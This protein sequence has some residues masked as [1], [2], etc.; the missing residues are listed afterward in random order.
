MLVVRT[1]LENA[2]NFAGLTSA[3]DFE[4]CKKR[5]RL[6]Y[7]NIG[8]VK[9]KIFAGEII[10]LPYTI[11]QKDRRVRPVKVTDDRRKKFSFKGI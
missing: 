9:A 1:Y 3:L 6:Y 11:L 2:K 4:D 5:L 7:R 8:A 10:N